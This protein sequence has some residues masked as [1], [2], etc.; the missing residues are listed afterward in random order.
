MCSRT[1]KTCPKIWK[2]CPKSWKKF[3]QN[4]EIFGKKSGN[5]QQKG[6][7]YTLIK[8]YIINFFNTLSPN[9]LW[10]PLSVFFPGLVLCLFHN[11]SWLKKIPSLKK[12]NCQGFQKNYQVFQHTFTKFSGKTSATIKLPLSDSVCLHVS[13]TLDTD[14]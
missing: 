7:E 3:L 5:Q 2:I 10:K 13:Q 9:L 11:L 8:F 14:L 12:Q 1:W 6:L 4:L